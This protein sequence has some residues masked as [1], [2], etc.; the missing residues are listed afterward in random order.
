[1]DLIFGSFDT[2]SAMEA[3]ENKYPNHDKLFHTD[4]TGIARK[5]SAGGMTDI[6]II[7]SYHY[8]V[9]N[10]SRNPS[11]IDRVNAFNSMIKDVNGTRRLFVSDKVSKVVE[12]LERH[13]FAD[14]GLPDKKSKYYDDIFDGIS[15]LA[16]PYSS[17]G[18]T[19]TVSYNR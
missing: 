3:L 18:K 5:T 19:K 6:K 15:Y 12:T 2:V 16:F 9:Q 11:I 8:R 4:A 17:Y 14:N 10:L 7:E 13:V 1:M